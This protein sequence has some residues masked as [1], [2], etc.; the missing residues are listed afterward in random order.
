[1]QGKGEGPATPGKE[2]LSPFAPGATASPPGEKYNSGLNPSPN[3]DILPVAQR[4]LWPQLAELPKHFVLY[5]G[6]GLALQ[7]GHRESVDFDFFSSRP[8]DPDRLYKRLDFLAGGEIIEK[9]RN[10]LTAKAPTSAGAVV[11][12]FFG[13]LRLQCVEKPLVM[14]PGIPLAGISDIFGCKC[15]AVQQ[16]QTVKDLIDI[17]AILNRTQLTLSDGLGFARAIYGEQF[18]PYVTLRALAYPPAIEGLSANQRTSLA[19][20]V[21]SVD[22]AAIPGVAPLGAIGLTEGIAP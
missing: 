6:T 20:S 3:L 7:L 12:S 5:G 17:C 15:G 13:G 4:Q 21:E 22:P 11:L 8:I 18:D 2:S 14:E 19:R 9:E 1:M 10:T 16:R